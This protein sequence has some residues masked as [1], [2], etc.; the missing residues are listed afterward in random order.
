MNVEDRNIYE[1]ENSLNIG[2]EGEAK[3]KDFLLSLDNVYRVQSVQN[4]K[5]Y[6]NDDIDFIVTLKGNKTYT[7]EVKTDTYKSGNLY[8]ETKSCIETNTLGCLEKTKA[9]FIFYYFNKFDR[10]YILKTNL[11]RKWVQQEIYKFTLNPEI[12]KLRKKEVFNK[13]ASGNEDDLYT[14]EG[15]TIPLYYLEGQLLNTK[16]YKRFDSLSKKIIAQ[17]A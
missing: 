7:V 5:K 10:L 2:N 17:T 4:I 8:Y 12:S 3:I 15:Y 11:F 14:S 16:I 1:F 9:D 6:Q 13:R